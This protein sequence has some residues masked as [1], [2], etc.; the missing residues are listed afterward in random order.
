MGQA[1]RRRSQWSDVGHVMGSG[2]VWLRLVKLWLVL[3][4]GQAMLGQS[5]G[6]AKQD[7]QQPQTE[8]KQDAGA[9]ISI[10]A[11]IRLER[12]LNPEL[13]DY[14]VGNLQL[15]DLQA[16]QR[17]SLNLTVVNPY[18]TPIKFSTIRTDC[19]C[20]KF[21]TQTDEI[22]ALGTAQFKVQMDVPNGGAAVHFR[23][24]QAAFFDVNSDARPV[25]RLALLYQLTGVFGFP[26]S[27]WNVE[28]PEAENL[29]VV[30]VPLVVVPPLTLDQ[31]KLEVGEPLKD[32]AVALIADD[33]AVDGPYVKFEV[34]R[35]AVPRQGLSGEIALRRTGTEHVSGMILSFKHPEKF[36]VRPE[37]LR[38]SRDHLSQPYEAVAMLR[39]RA[40][41]E[42]NADG[43]PDRAGSDLANNDRKT[44][45]SPPEIGLTIGKSAAQVLV[46]PL[47][48]SG[49]YR[50]NIRHNGPF[51]AD[52]EGRLKLR[53]K[54]VLNG[55]Q[56]V[57][58]SWAFLADLSAN[59]TV[60]KQHM[61]GLVEAHLASLEGWRSGD[62]LIRYST[63]EHGRHVE[64]QSDEYGTARL[65]EG[66][67]A[68]S[69]AVREDRLYRLA[70]DFDAERALVINRC[71]REER[72]FDGLDQELR[73]PVL[74]NDDRVLLYD[75]SQRAAF[76]RRDPAVIH[77]L[78][79]LPPMINMIA[80]W[81]V[82]DV[83]TLGFCEYQ[84]WDTSSWRPEVEFIGNVDFMAEIKHLGKNR[85]QV[86]SRNADVFPGQY[87]ID[88]DVK[89]N[90]PLKFV[91]YHVPPDRFPPVVTADVDWA[92]VDGQVVPASARLSKR[93]NSHYLDREFQVSIETTV[94]IHWFS[95]NQPLPD[96]LFDQQILHDRTKLDELLS[97]EV[98]GKMGDKR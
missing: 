68:M 5:P 17:Y 95:F 2:V 54:V 14:F 80:S 85:Y 25:V 38:L 40:P 23:R 15:P 74:R 20:A 70:F 71:E 97:E 56:H 21:E 27:R 84:S 79:Q 43:G 46:Q 28:L 45:E 31:L 93:D 63:V 10:D 82:P 3:T 61:S 57:I 83:R 41:I 87:V 16:T 19:G 24:T 60:D 65:I 76:V 33:P 75:K 32:F 91:S 50:L 42:A 88:W 29:V 96:N 51:D 22:P 1:R 92:A 69:V 81:G 49:I 36:S 89:R 90:V 59:L 34:P 35:K 7:L 86:V 55:E 66:P 47:E 72:L 6:W 62:L 73:R 98:F 94:E 78:D 67:D 37:S 26:Q 4:V 58:E 18:D 53:W 9:V 30:K 13:E 52:A 12:Q 39:V 44:A 77:R 48:N 8:K 11:V 64:F